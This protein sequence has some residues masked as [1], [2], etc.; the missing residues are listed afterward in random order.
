MSADCIG[1]LGLIGRSLEVFSGTP[2][3]VDGVGSLGEYSSSSIITLME[4][5]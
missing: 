5:I 2:R 1:R 3:M 4:D